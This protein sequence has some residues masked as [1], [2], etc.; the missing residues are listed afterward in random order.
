MFTSVKKVIEFVRKRRPTS[1]RVSSHITF[2]VQFQQ[3]LRALRMQYASL[4]MKNIT[5]KR[6]KNFTLEQYMQRQRI[7]CML[8]FFIVFNIQH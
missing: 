2:L 5:K 7:Q 1:L 6:K 8:Q 3:Y 4:N